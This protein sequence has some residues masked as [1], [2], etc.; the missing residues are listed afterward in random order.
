M[1]SNNAQVKV[2]ICDIIVRAAVSQPDLGLLMVNTLT[3]DVHD[4]NP[5]VRCTAIS[6]ICTLP[7]LQ[8]HAVQAFNAGLQDSNPTVRK[9]AVT[10]AGKLFRH[11]PS[12]ALAGDCVNKLYEMLRDQEPTVVTF[13]LQTIN[14]ILEREGGVVISKNMVSYF[15]KKVLDYPE[16]EFCFLMDYISLC[17]ADDELTLEMLNVLDPYL[18]K[19]SGNVVLS[20]GKLLSGLVQQNEALKSSLV[21][22]LV[23]VC[24]WFLKSR[25]YRDFQSQLLEF[26]HTLDEDYIKAFRTSFN[27]FFI[28][29]KDPDSLKRKK[30]KML[31]VLTSEDNCI[32]IANYLLNLLPQNKKI[33]R[34][35]ILALSD[36]ANKEPSCADHCIKNFDLLIKTDSEKYLQDILAHVRH[37]PLATS[38][39]DIVLQF[40]QTLVSFTKIED[41]LIVEEIS[42][43]LFIL[44]SFSGNIIE[45]PYIIEQLMALDQTDWPV[46]LF[47]QF[48]VSAYSVFLTHPPAMQLLLGEVI[49]ILL[50]I[51][52]HELHEKVLVY[53]TLLQDFDA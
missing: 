24:I 43:V 50:D 45:A 12:I 2:A 51:N 6:T 14:F 36:I 15:L 3:R 13:S 47:S 41:D 4:P 34:Q 35:I 44:R 23:P 20:V 27:N 48:L 46:H 8:N 30:I 7:V 39:G 26:I 22:R 33:N 1:A 53:Y 40:V 17:K 29:P 25:S 28:K 9:A 18:D 37:L 19:K 38:D 32:E 49:G 11:S 16:Q 5:L 42:S 21:Q 10:G 52:S 31:G